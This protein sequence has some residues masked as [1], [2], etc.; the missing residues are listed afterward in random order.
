MTMLA[1]SS[2]PAY[3]QC[4]I[5]PVH[6]RQIVALA[7]T[8]KIPLDLLFGGFEFG[9][10]DLVRNDFLVSYRQTVRFVKRAMSL[11]GEEALGLKVGM[12]QHPGSWGIVGLGLLACRTYG[13]AVSYG[14][15]N[16]QWLGSMV[17][18]EYTIE[19]GLV[20]VTA[21]PKFN[22]P[23][24]VRYL[25]EEL[26]AS[27]ISFTRYLRALD[28][29][30]DWIEFPYP[31][32][33]WADAYGAVIKCPMRFDAPH[34]RFSFQQSWLDKPLQ[35]HDEFMLAQSNHFLT[36]LNRRIAPNC[37]LV[38]SVQR[39]IRSHLT[40]GLTIETV[41]SHLHMSER[42]LRRRL[43]DRGLKFKDLL[44]EERRKSAARL[45]SGQDKQINVIAQQ[46]GYSNPSSFR[47]AFKKWT[48]KAPSHLK[49]RGTDAIPPSSMPPPADDTT[50]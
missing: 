14:M 12:T 39:Y 9:L 13:D 43:H 17:N 3:D 21:T 16:E 24:L 45:L 47:R 49:G 31:K 1:P 32:P 11:M 40:E 30:L 23:S 34:L 15:S 27:V 4:S 35:T 50:D 41:A 29:C 10:D 25:S 18:T 42:T 26:V 6:I 5:A 46:A 28:T 20:V 37:D 8:E 33:V 36:E 7:R 19:E 48:G 22:E 38:D 2:L 44:D